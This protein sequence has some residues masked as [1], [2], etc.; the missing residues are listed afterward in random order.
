M[1]AKETIKYRHQ[2]AGQPGFH[3]YNDLLDGFC[4]D[5]K[6]ESPVYLCLD[7]VAATLQTMDSGGA[8]VAVVLPRGVAREL[9]L[10]PTETGTSSA[11]DSTR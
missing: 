11:A 8:S 2:S 7:G 4:S 9:G 1:S 3:L 10:L 5:D 6:C